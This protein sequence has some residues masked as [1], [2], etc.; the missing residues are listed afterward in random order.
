M[1]KPWLDSVHFWFCFAKKGSYIP[2]REDYSFYILWYEIADHLYTK[3][4]RDLR[5]FVFGWNNSPLFFHQA[6][7]QEF[8]KRVLESEE[9]LFADDKKSLVGWKIIQFYRTFV[10][11]LLTIFITNPIY[12]SLWFTV[13]IL[14]FILH[15]TNRKPYKVS[16]FSIRNRFLRNRGLKR[17][18]YWETD[19]LHYLHL[20]EELF[21]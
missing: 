6:S 10:I 3:F 13:V 1:T 20:S 16:V 4:I 12:R 15:D 2:S 8:A 14:L 7:E 5:L 19:P 17:P 9:E 21:Y 11:N 18:E